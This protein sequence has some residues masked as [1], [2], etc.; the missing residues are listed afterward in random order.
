MFK[1]VIYIITVFAVIMTFAACSS[2]VDD[3]YT[4]ENGKQYLLVRDS[5]GNIVVNDRSKLLV[6][7]LNENGKKQK[8]DTGEYITEYIEFTGQVVIEN[9]VETNEMRFTLPDNFSANTEFPGYFSYDEYE[10]EIFIS[11]YND[12]I[13]LGTNSI[14]YNCE[15]LLESYGSDVFE[16][17]AYSVNIDGIECS[18]YKQV[19]TSSEYYM[20][21]FFYYIPYDTG[22]YEINCIISTEYA[23][24]VNFDKFAE[25]FEIK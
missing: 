9:A 1:R 19:C 4:A 16:Y 10:A 25:S 14:E 18:A 7:T 2:P 15:S 13:S 22:Y 20:N 11:Y 5:D 12:D 21:A 8:S 23:G 17:E 3:L 6:Y 24:R